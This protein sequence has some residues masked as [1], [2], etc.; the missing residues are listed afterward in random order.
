MLNARGSRF[1]SKARSLVIGTC[2]CCPFG[3][4]AGD[5]TG[6]VFL[7]IPLGSGQPFYGLQAGWQPSPLGFETFDGVDLSSAG[8][9]SGGTV[10]QWRNHFDGRSELWMNGTRLVQSDALYADGGVAGGE[11]ASGIDEYTVA[12]VIVGAVVVAAIVNADSVKGCAG[13]AC[14]TPEPAPVPPDP[15][16]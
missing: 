16:D 15:D 14:P 13:T 2:L 10:M 7:Q 9:S 8:G 11:T 3:A 4:A 12:A 5:L 6:G 1:A